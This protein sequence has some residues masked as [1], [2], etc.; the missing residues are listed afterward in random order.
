MGKIWSLMRSN[1]VELVLIKSQQL[2]GACPKTM[3][4][5]FFKNRYKYFLCASYTI[6]TIKRRFT[7]G[8]AGYISCRAE[9]ENHP[10]S[11]IKLE[12][13][14]ILSFFNLLQKTFFWH[15][16]TFWTKET[17]NVDI[18]EFLNI[19]SH[20]Y[21]VSRRTCLCRVVFNKKVHICM[22]W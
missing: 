8:L 17:E 21:R 13:N 9:T 5:P 12:R 15:L 11:N 2:F 18:V 7:R 19:Y 20:L 22:L 16:L 1:F 4:V 3:E 10:G 6:S 14:L